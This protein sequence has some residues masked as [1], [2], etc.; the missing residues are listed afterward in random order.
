MLTRPTNLH[1]EHYHDTNLQENIELYSW[2]FS[3]TENR[4]AAIQFIS[5]HLI[6]M[7][8]LES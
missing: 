1:S 3:S 4:F 8:S 5:Q 6:K 7:L 2:A